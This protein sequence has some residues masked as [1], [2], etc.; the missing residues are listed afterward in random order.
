ML[1]SSLV[2]LALAVAA[3]AGPALK[4]TIS[5]AENFSGIESAVVKATLTNTGDEV[6][7]ILNEPNT[8]LSKMETNTFAISNL[9]GV[10]PKFTG[11]IGKFR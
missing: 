3:Q 6:A 11:K 5:G 7:K 1:A 9:E 4:L 2:A 8:V 10:T